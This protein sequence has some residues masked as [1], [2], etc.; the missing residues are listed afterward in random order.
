MTHNPASSPLGSSGQRS[1][2][3][4]EDELDALLNSIMGND[5]GPRQEHPSAITTRSTAQQRIDQRAEQARLREAEQAN[6]ELRGQIHSLAMQVESLSEAA[7]THAAQGRAIAE[8]RDAM[9]QV[10]VAAHRQSRPAQ[11]ALNAEIHMPS[12]QIK[13][14]LFQAAHHLHQTNKEAASMNTWT[15]LFRG[16]VL[17]MLLPM[18]LEYQ[19]VP[20]MRFWIYAAV[21]ICAFVISVIFSFLTFQARRRVKR[22]LKAMEESAITRNV[23]VN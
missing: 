9:R 17:G 3:R 18:G 13:L 8:I 15:I 12:L 21:A 4:E 1:D 14:V 6:E 7:A 23:P 22:A 20:T 19:A 16:I 10:V 5:P 11:P 2:S